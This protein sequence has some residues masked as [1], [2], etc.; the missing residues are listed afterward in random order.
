MQTLNANG[1]LSHT[2]PITLK[3]PSTQ[4]PEISTVGPYTGLAEA[5]E[6]LFLGSATDPPELSV[7]VGAKGVKRIIITASEWIEVHREV[8]GK[9]SYYLIPASQARHVRL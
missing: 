7:R 6:V 5:A 1:I 4:R 2:T 8:N 3:G 9:V